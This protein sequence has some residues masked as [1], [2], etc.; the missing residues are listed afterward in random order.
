[1]AGE[2]G[3]LGEL[4]L[5]GEGVRGG[6]DSGVTIGMDSCIAQKAGGRRGMRV[7]YWN[8]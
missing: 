7:Q 5:E 3:E 6:D 4:E 8:E 1:M 2:Q